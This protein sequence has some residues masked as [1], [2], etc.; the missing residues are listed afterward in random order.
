MFNSPILS[1]SNKQQSSANMMTTKH[2]L[3]EKSKTIEQLKTIIDELQLRHERKERELLKR[4]GILFNE[5]QQNK[6]KMAHLI[7]KNQQQKKNHTDTKSLQNFSTQT[8]EN[9]LPLICLNC[10]SQLLDTSQCHNDSITQLLSQLQLHSQNKIQEQQPKYYT[11]QPEEDVEYISATPQ[12]TFNQSLSSPALST[13]DRSSTRSSCSRHH[14]SVS[15]TKHNES[16]SS[17][18]NTAESLPSSTYSDE[19]ESLERVLN[20]ASTMYTTHDNLQHTIK[21]QEELFRQ[22]LRLRGIT[23]E[24]DDTKERESSPSEHL[25][26]NI[27]GETSDI[28]KKSSASFRNRLISNRQKQSHHNITLSTD[29]DEQ[30]QQTQEKVKSSKQAKVRFIDQCHPI[31]KRKNLK[32]SSRTN[33]IV[34]STNTKR[35]YSNATPKNLQ[36]PLSSNM[37][38]VTIT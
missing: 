37:L 31:G 3:D 4:I 38:T 7:Y 20:A 12:P 28:E 2:M 5:L 26:D 27:D 22:H 9:N 8:D 36:L 14:C 35:Y 11:L 19:I 34:K 29:D 24:D 18:Y 1:R 6:K 25:Y 32:S 17:A 15:T 23:I 33:L 30:Q 21:L 16:S 10:S 13:T